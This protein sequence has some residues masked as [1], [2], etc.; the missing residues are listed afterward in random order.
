MEVSPDGLAVA[1]IANEDGLR[2][3]HLLDSQS[4]TEVGRASHIDAGVI[5]ALRWRPTGHELGFSLASARTPGDT[6]SINLETRNWSAGPSARPADWTLLNSRNRNSSTGNPST[7]V[8]SP[9]SCIRRRRGFT[10]P[11]P[12]IIDIHGGPESQF[13]PSYVGVRNYYVNE[14]GVALIFPNVRAQRVTARLFSIW[15]TDSSAKIP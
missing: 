7:A 11:R 8:R 4:R 6:Y 12:V 15:I 5:T 14:L 2:K 13:R 1:Y 3:L 10:G 9:A